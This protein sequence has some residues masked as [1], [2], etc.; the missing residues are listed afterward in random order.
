M[1]LFKSFVEAIY[2]AVSSASDVLTNKNQE[3]LEQYFHE[4]T[5][6]ASIA[7]KDGEKV[8]CPNSIYLDY[9]SLNDEGNTE[10]NAVQVPLISLIPVSATQIE[11][12]TFTAEFQLSIENEELYIDFPQSSRLRKGRSTLGKLEIIISPQEPTEGMQ[13]IISA[14]ENSLKRQIAE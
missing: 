9:P 6:S 5:D 13:Q 3:I 8:L 12:A 1:M 14:Y 7:L 10:R 2:R 11:K 4:S